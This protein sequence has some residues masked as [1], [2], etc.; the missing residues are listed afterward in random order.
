MMTV[1][2]MA[3][4]IAPLSDDY[5]DK[6]QR[7]LDNLTKPPGSLGKL[8]TIARKYAAIRETIDPSITR[9]VIVTFAGDHGIVAKGVSAY[10]REVTIQMVLNMLDGGAAVNV[11]AR[12]VGAE[13]A[14]VDIGVDFDFEPHKR[15]IMRKVN[16]GTRDFTEGPAMSY[17]EALRAMEIGIELAGEYARQGVDIIGTGEMGIGN[18]TP[19]TAI[20][21][22]LS[23]IP[24]GDITG[25][26]TGIDDQTLNNKI[27]LIEQG[28][29]VNRPDPCDS[30]DVLAKVGGFEIGGIAGLIIGAAYHR[31]PVI[32]DGFISS[33]GALIAVTMNRTINDYL[34]Y[35]HLSAEAGHRAMLTALEQEP[36]M[37]LDMRLGE[38]TGS[39]IAM[40]VI[41]GAIKI[42]TGMATFD[43]AGVDRKKE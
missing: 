20:L 1:K 29:A 4:R 33:A 32:I 8:E 16:R 40:S 38:G 21:S 25:R 24:V 30:V 41:E 10:P 14:V 12:H 7:R 23:S 11:L 43:S 5:L 39:A 31:L 17:D 36:I 27:K 3:R 28:I 18:T 6:A 15:L 22:V 34:F 13:V 42:M 35:S 26:G 2:D 19:S 9:K 37:N